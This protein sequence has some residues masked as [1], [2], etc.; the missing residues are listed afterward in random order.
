M[1]TGIIFLSILCC[2]HLSCS[3]SLNIDNE[4][5]EHVCYEKVN[6]MILRQK[7]LDYL[8]Q[9]ASTRSSS[10]EVVFKP[11]ELY[12]FENLEIVHSQ[13]SNEEMVVVRNIMNANNVM[14][15]YKDNGVIRNCLI[16]EYIPK[17]DLNTPNEMPFVCRDN[18]NIPIFKAVINGDNNTCKVVEIFTGFDQINAGVRNW[19]CNLSLGLS[20]IIWST[21]AGMAATGAGVVVG[22]AWLVF[23]T[24][25]FDAAVSHETTLEDTES[26]VFV[27]DSIAFAGHE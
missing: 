10:T 8:E 22:I 15:F 17:I 2:F 26:A 27:N 19:G 12:D 7:I 6:N 13:N 5:Q 24:W 16:V 1:K 21:A 9:V 23:Q 20:G 11:E 14:A 3:N 25:A 4:E 18:N